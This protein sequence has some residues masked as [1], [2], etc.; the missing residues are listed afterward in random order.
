V[1]KSDSLVMPSRRETCSLSLLHAGFCNSIHSR[2]KMPERPI[3]ESAAKLHST[4]PIRKDIQ[5]RG[6]E[7]P[8]MPIPRTR[9]NGLL[10][11]VPT[12]PSDHHHRAWC[13]PDDRVRDAAHQS[14]PHPP[15]PPAAHHDQTDP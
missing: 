1:S 10:D 3:L 13:V 6:C 2:Y 7:F 8:R 11:D 9:V 12:S 5:D 14:P 15:A 4:G